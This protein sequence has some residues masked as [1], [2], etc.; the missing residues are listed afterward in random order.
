MRLS[1]LAVATTSLAAA[2]GLAAVVPV[3]AEPANANCNTNTGD[4][5]SEAWTSH[6][7]LGDALAGIERR[8]GGTVDVEVAGYAN[9]GRELWTARVGTG[10]K[11][12]LVTSQIHGNEPTGTP[13][14]VSLLRRLGADTGW[15]ARM[16]D[17]VTVVAVP[18]MNPDGAALDRRGNDRTWADVVEDFPQLAGAEPAWN[19]Y[20]GTLQGDDYSQRPGFDVN[21]DYHPDLGYVPQPADFPGTSDDPGWY[22]QP[23]SQTIRNVY[24][25]LQREFGAVDAYVDLHHQAPCYTD[26]NGEDRVTMSLSG[27]F[28]ADPSSPEGAE[29]SQFA[30]EYRPDYSKQL[31]LT[32]YD[33]LSS[34]GESPFGNITLYPQDIN[35]PGT[36]LGS[37]ALNGSGTVLFEVRGQT[38]SWGAK[39]RGQ[40]I[41]TVER[42]MAGI[43]EGI[44]SGSVND[45]D[46]ARYDDIPETDRGGL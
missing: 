9:R 25:G 18:H 38:H 46:P 42:G 32:A 41:G 34:Y 29:W 22:I 30:D 33:A 26:E 13:A 35:L 12:I 23:E 31:T 39:M 40:L 14:M 19:Y 4:T 16:R 1:K 45:L 3:H 2:L 28:V 10:D 43:I 20:T 27:K 15:A 6:Q 44:A 24:V 8:S 7:E 21:R 5:G 11:A 17:A 36:G 37:F